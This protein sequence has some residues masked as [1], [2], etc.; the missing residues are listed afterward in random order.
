M[1]I[2]FIPIIV[3]DIAYIY[4]QYENQNKTCL[5]IILETH[6]E[7]QFIKVMASIFCHSTYLFLSLYLN[8][9]FLPEPPTHQTKSLRTGDNFLNNLKQG[10]FIL[11][12]IHLY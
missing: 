7:G 12:L 4:L 1:A 8:I 3:F 10:T 9:Y 5:T 2:Y 6:V 11:A